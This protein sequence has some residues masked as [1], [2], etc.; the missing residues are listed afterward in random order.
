VIAVSAQEI[1]VA[2]RVSVGRMFIDATLD[3]VDRTLLRDRRRAAADGIVVPVVAIDR[4]GGA[5]E[6]YSE[7][8]TRGFV[9]GGEGCAEDV[10]REARQVLVDSFKDASP[11]ERTDEALLKARIQTSLKRFLRRKTQR[12]P[13][14][15]PVIVEL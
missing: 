3:R 11:A 14:I 2:D 8:V 13:L 9:P 15:I 6:G 10:M 5:V 7:I 4:E 12:Q 1:T